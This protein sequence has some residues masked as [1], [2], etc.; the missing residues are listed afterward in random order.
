[1]NVKTIKFGFFFLSGLD[2]ALWHMHAKAS[3]NYILLKI[4]ISLYTYQ[5]LL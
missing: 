3:Y 2:I 5:N 1:L 4:N